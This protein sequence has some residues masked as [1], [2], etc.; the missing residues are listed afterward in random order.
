[1]HKTD[2]SVC[3][4]ELT[5]PATKELIDTYVHL[6]GSKTSNK[7]VCATPRQL[8]SLVRLAKALARMQLR[9]AVTVEHVKEAAKLITAATYQALTDPLTGRIDFERMA[10]GVQAAVRRRNE[11]ICDIVLELLKHEE[12]KSEGISFS[13]ME[14]EVEKSLVVRGEDP[15][16]RR[17]MERVANELI[18]TGIL[19]YSRASSRYTAR[20]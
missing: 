19:C 6:R 15:L 8:D 1:M 12:F 14:E 10:T 16:T 9:D 13:K 11:A 17:E 2:C 5:E 18:L 3:K 4:P 7:S 20:L